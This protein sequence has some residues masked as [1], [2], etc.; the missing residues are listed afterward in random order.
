MA[1]SLVRRDQVRLCLSSRSALR[2]RRLNQTVSHHPGTRVSFIHSHH[3]RFWNNGHLRACTVRI[4]KPHRRVPGSVCHCFYFPGIPFPETYS[5][6][7]LQSISPAPQCISSLRRRPTH[8]ILGDS[9]THLDRQL[10]R[11]ARWPAS[12][13]LIGRTWS[14]LG[15][16]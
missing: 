6:R 11:V 3:V 2:H 4:R 7:F 10:L 8:V 5:C 9:G 14:R 1:A 12:C 13:I 15:R 16:Q